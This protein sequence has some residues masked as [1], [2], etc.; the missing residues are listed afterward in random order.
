MPLSLLNPSEA[1]AFFPLSTMGRMSI[2]DGRTRDI[3]SILVRL[4]TF[5]EAWTLLQRD[6]VRHPL[7]F[8]LLYQI[9]KE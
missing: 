9:S 8:V 2:D 6:T 1:Y 3:F 5:H 7:S 4:P